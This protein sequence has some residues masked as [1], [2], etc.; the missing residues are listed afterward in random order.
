MFIMGFYRV[1]ENPKVYNLVTKIISFNN[2]GLKKYLPKLIK[3][4]KSD[5]ILDVGC[6]TG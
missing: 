2:Q 3:V 1:F 6:G 5:C 4:D